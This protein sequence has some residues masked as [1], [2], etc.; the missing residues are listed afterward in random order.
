MWLKSEGFVDREKLWW[1]SYHSQGTS[2]YILPCKL[3][4]LKSDLKAWNEEKFGNIEK[5]K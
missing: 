5:K 1:S 2:S 4:A 3:K